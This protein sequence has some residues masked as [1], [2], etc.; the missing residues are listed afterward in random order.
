LSRSE[1][2]IAERAPPSP[3]LPHDHSGVFS[4]EVDGDV[5][6]ERSA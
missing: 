4:H 5:S 2:E 3:A 6:K 1:K